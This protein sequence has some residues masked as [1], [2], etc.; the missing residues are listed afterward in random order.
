[1][2]VKNP[3]WGKGQGQHRPRSFGVMNKRGREGVGTGYCEGPAVL[4]G[5]WGPNLGN[6]T[7]TLANTSGRAATVTNKAA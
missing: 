3:R 5:C 1:M 2:A 4:G 7:H 6:T